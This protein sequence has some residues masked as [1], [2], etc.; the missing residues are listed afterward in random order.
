[1]EAVAVTEDESPPITVLGEELN[2][3]DDGVWTG[4]YGGNASTITLEAPRA[5]VWRLRVETSNGEIVTEG[6]TREEAEEA[7]RGELLWLIEDLGA[8]T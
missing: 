3:E 2:E 6:A 5:P 8:L 1:M 4:V 7:M